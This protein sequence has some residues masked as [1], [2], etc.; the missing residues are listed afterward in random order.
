MTRGGDAGRGRYAPP[1]A[2][3]ELEG[4]VP[5]HGSGTFS[6]TQALEDAWKLTWA[7]FG[8]WLSVGVI[9][10]LVF[11]LSGLTIVGIPLVWPVLT[12][13]LAVFFLNLYEGKQDVGDLFSGFSRYGSVLWRTLVLLLIIYVAGGLVGLAISWIRSRVLGIGDSLTGIMI[14]QVV[15][16]GFSILVVARFYFAL[17]FLVEKD[18]GP[19]QAMEASWNVTRGHVLKVALVAVLS[20]TLAVIGF[21]FLIVGVIPAI[22]M[23]YLM[24]ISAYRQIVGLPPSDTADRAAR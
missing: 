3:L 14:D 9:A 5:S 8:S 24:W 13:G 17:P 23:G 10:F 2:P 22:T 21:L 12:F 7:H 20:F 18:L 6:V 1:A 15:S 19:L 4:F 11:A 16:A